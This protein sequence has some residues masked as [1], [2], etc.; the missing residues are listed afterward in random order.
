[1]RMQVL[2]SRC[3]FNVSLAISLVSASLARSMAQ[4]HSGEPREQ[5]WH[6]LASFQKFKPDSDSI[7][8]HV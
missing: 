4:R 5:V 2:T 6:E 7:A 1:M 8:E 3:D